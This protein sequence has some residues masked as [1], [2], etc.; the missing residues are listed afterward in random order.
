RL[1]AGHTLWQLA[2]ILSS[3]RRRDEAE[4]TL[5]E[6][7]ELFKALATDFPKERYYRQETAFSYRLLCDIFTGAGRLREEVDYLQRAAEIYANL[8]AEE[9]NSDFYRGESSL[10]YAR[11][12]QHYARLSQW[13]KAA[14]QYAKAVLLAR[15][16]RDDAFAY[17]CLFLIRGD[18]E[19]YNRS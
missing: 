18:S 7:L 11:L 13:D 9:P 12:A 14:A 19:G 3:T 8:V 5:R 4:K 16:L 6:A 10:V 15:P 17:A 1:E 2:S